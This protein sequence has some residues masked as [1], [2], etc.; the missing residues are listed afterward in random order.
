MESLHLFIPS[1]YLSSVLGHRQP[2]ANTNLR[3]PESKDRSRVP[4]L[5]SVDITPGQGA[6]PGHTRCLGILGRQ[7]LVEDRDHSIIDEVYC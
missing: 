5:Q 4:S 3:R 6:E 1:S 2:I 7:C